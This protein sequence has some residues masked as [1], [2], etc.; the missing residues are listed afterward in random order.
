M[1]YT[2]LSARIH[3]SPRIRRRV[4]LIV[5]VGI[6][7]T[8]VTVPLLAQN[9]AEFF[10][11]STL[12]VGS[13]VTALAKA[14]FDRDGRL[15]L[16]V[17][18]RTAGTVTIL[19]NL[20]KRF[21][22][23]T[24]VG[25][26]VRPEGLLVGDFNHDDRVD[27]VVIA[28][29]VLLYKQLSLGAFRSPFFESPVSVSAAGNAV[30]GLASGDFN[31]DGHPDLVSM[32]G[33]TGLIFVAGKADGF[34]TTGTRINSNITGR[35]FRVTDVDQDA[36]L[37]LLYG[38]GTGIDV[39]RNNGNGT[40]A[41]PQA[42]GMNR[43]PGAMTLVKWT[44]DDTA[45]LV[46]APAAAAQPVSVVRIADGLQVEIPSSAVVPE[47]FE[48]E[49]GDAT[50]DGIDDVFAHSSRDRSVTLLTNP[51]DLRFQQVRKV[52]STPLPGLGGKRILAGDFNNDGLADLV[53]AQDN[54]NN[55][56]GADQI[57]L[58]VN[59]DKGDRLSA[60]VSRTILATGRSVVTGFIIEDVPTRVLIRA[61]GPGLG[62]F[63]ITGFNRNPRFVVNGNAGEVG[64]NDNWSAAAANLQAVN[65]AS[66]TTGAFALTVGSTDAATVLTL[67]PGSYTVVTTGDGAGE[68]YVDVNVIDGDF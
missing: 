52:A 5:A 54:P 11:A 57:V 63:G 59:P 14:D 15:D 17:L 29:P 10:P 35:A 20:S 37:D 27:L 4:W 51:N 24:T 22:V 40:F 67:N 36:D 23:M 58:Y 43:R 26:G 30:A 21:A 33:G 56:A 66:R 6:L 2:T 25:A 31:R 49:L 60:V 46:L 18:D 62:Q 32:S 42:R 68:V 64:R 13:D 47:I 45:D 50:G 53:V 61:V 19:R 44:R 41:A 65:S 34:V 38:T 3:V 39:L 55:V 7:A 12:N 1:H 48:F 8:L 28:S 9:T 16:A